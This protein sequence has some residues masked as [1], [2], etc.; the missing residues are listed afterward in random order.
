MEYEALA[1]EVGARSVGMKVV[2]PPIV[3]GETGVD[4]KFTFVAEADGEKYAFD[5]YEDVGEVEVLRTYIKKFDTGAVTTIVC[6]K[7]IPTDGAIAL[8]RE[9]GI[10]LL[11]K[12]GLGAAFRQQMAE[13]VS[14]PL[15]AKAP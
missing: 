10:R 14:H 13:E 15:A 7:H 3:S 6:M 5:L 9:Y 11:S 2:K 4:H 1:L 8:A 12:E